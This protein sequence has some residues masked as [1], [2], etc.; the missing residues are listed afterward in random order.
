M[1]TRRDLLLGGGGLLAGGLLGAGLTYS[2]VD[3]PAPTR[4]RS[5]GLQNH[6][7]RDETVTVTLDH[8]SGETFTREFV[9]PAA[10]DQGT[11][12]RRITPYVPAWTDCRIEGTCTNPESSASFDLGS[13]PPGCLELRFQVD[14]DGRIS[15]WQTA[16]EPAP[17]PD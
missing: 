9:A 4:F 15:T 11:Y 2:T 12:V 17:M 16:C 6:Q 1:R 5:L 7:R 13:L 14:E 3:D 8:P 10:T